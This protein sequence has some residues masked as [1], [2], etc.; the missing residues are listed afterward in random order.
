MKCTA[1]MDTGS[2]VSIFPARLLSAARK[3]GFDVDADVEETTLKK[4]ARVYDASGYRM[5]FQGAVKL[6][7]QVDHGETQRIAFLVDS[8]KHGMILLGTNAL[9]KL[10]WKLMPD[11]P[12]WRA[13]TKAEESKKKPGSRRCMH[14]PV[15]QHN[16]KSSKEVTVAGRVYLKPGET[17]MISVYCDDM[18]QKGVLWSSVA[19]LPDTVCP[20]TRCCV[21]IP[22]RN[23]LAGAKVFRKGEVVGTYEPAEI[24]EH[25][26]L[27]YESDVLERTVEISAN[28]L[29]KLLSILGIK[30]QEGEQTHG[31]AKLIKKYANMFAVSEQELTQTSLV[32]HTIDTG[33]AKPIRQKPRPVPLATRMELRNILSDLQERKVIEPSRS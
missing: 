29:K 25:E 10:G 9:P 7:L 14:G 32:E 2:Q 11:K 22:V 21:Q 8:A 30:K 17:K 24:V 13:R 27:S 20:G 6:S 28:R 15:Q 5:T 1:L 16:T 4:P 33:D 3:N 26:P 23:S 19:A 31:L 12:Q 18:K